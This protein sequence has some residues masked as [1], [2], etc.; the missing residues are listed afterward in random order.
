MCLTDFKRVG[1]S[2]EQQSLVSARVGQKSGKGITS[3]LE[4]E[5]EGVRTK[6][7]VDSGSCCTLVSE[8]FWRAHGL[9]K[10]RKL[11]TT[12]LVDTF[13]VNGDLLS[14]LGSKEVRIKLG[15]E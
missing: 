6:S 10:T 7:L 1:A 2:S 4:V 5:V 15:M 8:T 14:L 9:L 3:I 12:G 13:S 11:E